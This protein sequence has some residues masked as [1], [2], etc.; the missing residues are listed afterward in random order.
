MEM[1]DA[2]KTN[3]NVPGTN[4]RDIIEV[5][6]S[7]NINF[8]EAFT[9]ESCGD[10]VDILNTVQT[11]DKLMGFT[12]EEKY[13]R[14]TI[15]SE[16]GSIIALMTLLEKIEELKE[17]GYT[18][19]THVSGMAASCGFI[20]FASGTYRTVSQFAYLLNHQGSSMIRGTI[21]EMEVDLRFSKMLE[22]QLNNYL[23]EKTDMSEE[24][25]QRPYVTNTDI[26]YNSKEAIECGIAHEIKNY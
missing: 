14:I 15:V 26:W 11:Y 13:I 18:V 7:R 9:R 25:I 1:S 3:N 2:E 16:G 12:D 22:E 20:L 24:E 4:N 5:L 21:K 23:R 17:Q 19:H 10:V 8:N 6:E